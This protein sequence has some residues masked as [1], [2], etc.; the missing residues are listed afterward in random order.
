MSD[1]TYPI[2]FLVGELSA[3]GQFSTE[4]VR[5]ET[6]YVQRNAV[7]NHPL[8]RFTIRYSYLDA[9]WLDELR[10]FWLRHR[11]A[12]DTFRFD[13]YTDPTLVDRVFGVGDGETRVFKLGHDYT[14]NPTIE[15]DAQAVTAVY[16]SPTNGRVVFETAPVAGAVLTYSADAAGYRVRFSDTFDY[17]RLMEGAFQNLEVVLDQTLDDQDQYPIRQ[18]MFG[19]IITT[20]E[21]SAVGDAVAF[22]FV[23]PKG[24]TVTS[25]S[26]YLASMTDPGV[27]R[28][29][30]REDDDGE[31]GDIVASG[32]ETPGAASTWRT[33]NVSTPAA[34]TRG[35]RYWVVVEALSGT[36]DASH[37]CAVKF[38]ES[39]PSISPLGLQD[40][41]LWGSY[42]I[43]DL[44]CDGTPNSWLGVE[45][46]EAG[47]D[48]S[49]HDRAGHGAFFL[50]TSAL[51][52]VGHCQAPMTQ[53]LAGDDRIRQKIVVE[54]THD[55]TI[56]RIGAVF[57]T[58][59]APADS[60]Y[61]AIV[62]DSDPLVIQ[63]TGTLATPRS[64]GGDPTYI[65]TRLEQPLDIPTGE[66][67]YIVFYSTSSV[68]PDGWTVYGHFD[69]WSD[70]AAGWN[71][72]WDSV[73]WDE[74]ESMALI[75]H[76]GGL[77]YPIEIRGAWTVR[78]RGR[79][80]A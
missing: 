69:S 76:D 18:V 42:Q 34:I 3:Q 38:T 4:Q 26:Y 25:I 13:D 36:W 47:G 12:D 30:V 31:P 60:L 59:T 21:L 79:W 71:A 23:A 1:E 39:V 19:G 6:G 45:G 58:G 41:M 68:A 67:V 32:N 72:N 64:T 77:T 29:S 9:D 20:Q 66:T 28:I 75:S 62:F 35:T 11:G 51:T 52:I 78:C 14:D 65:Q 61:Y 80:E 56:D 48:W 10:N 17:G 57:S 40:S 73:R 53:V 54:T 27:V 74:D 33:V 63:R 22:S 46:S 8:W 7:W 37:K 70:Y 24:V 16:V 50:N 44:R 5:F 43:A 2:D 55:F 15:A 49:T